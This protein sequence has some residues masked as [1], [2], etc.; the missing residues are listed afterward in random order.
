MDG[1]VTDIQGATL[2]NTDF[3]RAIYTGR[4]LQ[5]VLMALLPGEDMG[6]E[7]HPTHDQFF[8]VESGHGDFIIDCVTTTI[9]DGWAMIVPAGARH[10]VI[11]TGDKPLRL[12]TI[13]APPRHID[14]IVKSTRRAAVNGPQHFD[15]K[16]SE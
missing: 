8:H 10:N 14:R 13:Y 12:Y 16:T 6:D 3:R 7:V 1:L 5:L 2:A 9:D 11:N 4:K 15:G